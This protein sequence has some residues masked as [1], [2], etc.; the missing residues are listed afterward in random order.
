[1]SSVTA[2]VTTGPARGIRAPAVAA[3]ARALP[4]G[5]DDD[6]AQRPAG[7]PGQ[8]L[9]PAADRASSLVNQLAFVAFGNC[10]SSLLLRR[11]AGLRGAG[12]R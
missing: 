11:Y 12:E 1:M 4:D 6:R 3:R 10:P 8:P 9:V 2:D 7:R 5:G